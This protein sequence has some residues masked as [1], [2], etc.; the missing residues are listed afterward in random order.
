MRSKGKCHRQ[1]VKQRISEQ[2][3]QFKG[4][5]VAFSF[6]LFMVTCLSTS[7]DCFA[8]SCLWSISIPLCCSP[9]LDM[10]SFSFLPFSSMHVPHKFSF[11]MKFRAIVCAILCTLKEPRP[12]R[13]HIAYAACICMYVQQM[14]SVPYSRLFGWAARSSGH[15]YWNA[16]WYF[17]ETKY[18]KGKVSSVCPLLPY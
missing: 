16:P 13:W 4:V 11:H 8:V 9:E 7:C 14:E 1:A 12:D 3:S 18:Q 2:R 17:A 10:H 5:P 15:R 6:P